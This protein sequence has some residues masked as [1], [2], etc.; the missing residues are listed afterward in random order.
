MGIQR[1]IWTDILLENFYPDGSFLNEPRDLSAL[2][3][4]SKIHLAEAGANPDVLIDNATYP[5]TKSARVDNAI[6]LTMRVLDTTST[7]VYNTEEKETSYD[8]MASVVYGHR[9]Q[10][11]EKATRLAAWNYTPTSDGALTPIIGASGATNGLTNAR[12]RLLYADV[13][14]MVTAFDQANVP[15]EGRILVLC[16][17]HQADLIM[18]DKE[19]Y[20]PLFEGGKLFGMKVY[21]SAATPTFNI[22][23]TKKAFDAVADPANDTVASFVFHKD[24]AMKA[25]GDADVFWTEKDPDYKADIINFQIR[26]LA[27]MLRNKYYGAIYSPT[28]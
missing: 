21:V 9:S 25:I 1:E 5:I 28:V 2:V 23:G 3:N 12:K 20:K 17:Q 19:L 18:E 24:E 8:K 6:E 26:F 10:L 13:L 11:Q 16:P 27:T 7:I 14:K 4:N 15:S 22:G